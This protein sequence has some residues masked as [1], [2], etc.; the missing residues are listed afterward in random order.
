MVCEQRVMIGTADRIRIGVDRGAGQARHGVD[1]SVF[2][3]DG[4][5]A[6]RVTSEV[7]NNACR[8][9]NPESR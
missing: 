8:G 2:G 9:Q 5:V 1:E 3:I 6:S 4:T 7:P